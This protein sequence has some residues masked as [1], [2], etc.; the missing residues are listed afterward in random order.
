MMI[1]RRILPDV[2]ICLLLGGP[3]PL[4][5]DFFPPPPVDLDS[6]RLP[7]EVEELNKAI[8]SF[9]QG[10]YEQTL[11]L[12]QAAGKKHESLL[13]PRLIL[14]KLF[15]LHN[16]GKQGRDVLEQAA[17]ETPEHPEIYLIFGQ[18]ALQEGRFTDARLHF[19]RATEL[20]RSK[21]WPLALQE[22][23]LRDAHAGC[24]SEAEQRRCWTDAEPAL[25]AWLKLEPKN[26]AARQRLGVVLFRQGKHGPART[27]LEQA[28]HDDPKLEPAALAL[29]W[30][31]SEI[32][33][34]DKAA[35]WMEAAVKQ[36]PKD[37]RVHL[38][39]ARWLLQQ[40]RVEEARRAGDSAAELAPD[41]RDTQ[42]VRG[43]IA[44]TRKDY[45]TSERLFQALHQQSPGDFAISNQL[46]LALGEQDDEAKRHKALQLAEINARLYPNASEA[47]STLG[48]LY[49]R[50]GRGDEAE[51]ALRASLSGGAGSSDTIYYL[52]RLLG[53]RGQADEA[54]RLLK[55][56]LDAPGLF[57]FRKQA[58]GQ[59]EQLNK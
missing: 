44:W 54:K 57:S 41:S 11:K 36:S 7:K 49:Y 35:Q 53:E 29:G 12:L 46:A 16:Q 10:D 31:Y 38:G 58:L 42:F 18:L 19:N 39:Y 25:T 52:A 15:L 20:A 30:L 32:G 24:A 59:L 26:G 37:F 56:A 27:E 21:Q 1:R 22:E 4:P 40:N 55:V 9:Q 23:F 48:L 34:R 17:L 45:A 14:A 3:A 8:Q 28:E 6:L 47:L 51:K 13:P 5:A 2:A 50:L 43:L 33:Q